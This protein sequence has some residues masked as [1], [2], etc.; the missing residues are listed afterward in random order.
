MAQKQVLEKKQAQA[1]KDSVKQTEHRGKHTWILVSRERILG[2]ESQTEKIY[3]DIYKERISLSTTN[4][5]PLRY[6]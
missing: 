3:S 2:I 4:S 5:S 6:I 1:A